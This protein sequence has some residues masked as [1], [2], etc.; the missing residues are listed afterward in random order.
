[1]S[2]P[3]APL[4]GTG[5]S[6]NRNA[7]RGQPLRVFIDGTVPLEKRDA[8]RETVTTMLATALKGHPQFANLAALVS[9]EARRG[10]WQVTVVAL[11]PALGPLS[12]ELPLDGMVLDSMLEALA[13]L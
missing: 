11:D 4:Q 7:W 3:S 9:R 6:P 8:A 2:I 5:S 13:R 1:M 12:S 10:G